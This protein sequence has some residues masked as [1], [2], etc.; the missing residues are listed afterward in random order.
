[1]LTPNVAGF[2]RKAQVDSGLAEQVR[3]ADSYQ[4]LAELSE[5]AGEPAAAGDLRAAFAARNA[6]VLAQQMIR[7]GVID[8]L[9][10]ASVPAMDE[11]LWNR[12]A[13]MD[14]SSVVYQLVSY[15]G[16]TA[17]RAASVEQRY[18]RFF[19]L[20][21]ILPDGNA[22]PTH[23]IDE[24]WH[25][26]I[27]NTRQYGPDC[28]RVAGRFVHHTFPSLADPAQVRALSTVWLETWVSYEALFDAPYEE[29]IGA[30]L[31]QRWPK[32]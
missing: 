32:V 31:L 21:A 18:R 17:E 30:A 9:P 23:E 25:Q 27:I 29:T 6:G 22:S 3:N 15:Q 24:F 12:V 14:L 5:R 19:Y 20:K 8:A 26:H 11:E 10:P 28:Q 2:L 7:R 16:W 13:A 4:A 1:M